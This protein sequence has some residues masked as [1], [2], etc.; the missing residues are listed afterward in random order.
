MELGR[1]VLIF[2]GPAYLKKH[3]IPRPHSPVPAEPVI[4]FIQVLDHFSAAHRPSFP[5]RAQNPRSS[6]SIMRNTTAPLRKMINH[7]TI[8]CCKK[9]NHRKHLYVKKHLFSLY[10]EKLLPL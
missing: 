3:R 9:V 10:F 6:R 8:S 1:K 5:V 7:N 4:V 2:R